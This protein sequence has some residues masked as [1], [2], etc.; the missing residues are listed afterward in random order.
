LQ[1]DANAEPEHLG[2]ILKFIT[3]H[4]LQKHGQGFASTLTKL[5]SK[6]ACISLPSNPNKKAPKDGKGKKRKCEDAE[7]VN[8]KGQEMDM[9]TKVVYN[10]YFSY[11][12]HCGEMRLSNSGIN[13]K[14]CRE[15]AQK[16]GITY[17]IMTL[18]E[19][20]PVLKHK[21]GILEIELSKGVSHALAYVTVRS[22]HQFQHTVSDA[23]EKLGE[24]RLAAARKP[25]SISPAV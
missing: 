13:S 23:Y 25:D 9:S 19:K 1:R 12:S 21:Y 10:D 22:G 7:T 14:V 2:W 17:D 20:E 16:L 15:I 18:E 6:C 3:E 8:L 11:C 24:L 5:P 4:A